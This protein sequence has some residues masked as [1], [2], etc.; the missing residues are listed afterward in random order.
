[1]SSRLFARDPRPPFTPSRTPVSASSTQRATLDGL[2]VR[3]SSWDEWVAAEA[4]LRE[5][6]PPRAGAAAAAQAPRR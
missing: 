3:D 4:L 2:E 6:Q 1:M 5:Q